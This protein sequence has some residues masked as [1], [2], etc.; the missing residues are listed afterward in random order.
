MNN[1]PFSQIPQA[2]S[3]WKELEEQA[4]LQQVIQFKSVLCQLISSLDSKISEQLS[5]IIQEPLFKQLESSWMGLQS[6]TQLSISNRRVKIKVLDLSWELL[7]SDINLSFDIKQSILFKKL[8]S[9]E[10]DTAGGAPFGLVIVDHKVHPDYDEGCGY[11]DLYTLQLLSELAERAMCPIVLGV[12]EFFFGDEPNR[13]LQDAARIDRIL[14]SLDYRSWALLRQKESAR[15]LHLVMP[16][17]LLRSAYQGYAA[18]FIFNEVNRCENA[19]WG[20]ASYLLASNVIREFD[21][22]SWF[23]FLRSYNEFGSYGAIVENLEGKPT[24]AKVDIFSEEDGFWAEHGFIVLSSLYLTQQK[25]F[26]SNQ[27]VWRAPNDAAKVLGMLQTSLMACRFGHYIKAQMRDQ[28]G[29]YDSADDCKR[30]LE[31]W[32]QK[33]ISEVD[34]GEDSVMARYPLKACEVTL[35]ED[36][37]DSTRYLCQI[38]LQ[39]QYQY[40]IMD[41][42]VVLST[43]ISRQDVGDK[44]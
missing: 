3:F 5:Q 6:L 33:Y 11:D 29:R 17:Y 12:D 15:F 9:N 23:G 21:R 40:D 43:S 1:H 7:S 32:L 22:I 20:N 39:P 27:S 18:G 28:I 8:Y 44:A 26:F 16:E 37:Q 14:D 34:Y 38:M 13:Q 42:Q 25:G 2:A 36:P 24:Q 31:R 19:L 35:Q 4:S 30:N 10:F 41:A